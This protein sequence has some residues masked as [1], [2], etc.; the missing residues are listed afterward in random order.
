[1]LVLR[2]KVEFVFQLPFVVKLAKKLAA[3]VLGALL[4]PINVQAL[5]EHQYKLDELPIVG[6]THQRSTVTQVNAKKLIYVQA[7][8]FGLA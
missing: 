2:K 3:F 4:P 6:F 1:M 7:V 8:S 5:M